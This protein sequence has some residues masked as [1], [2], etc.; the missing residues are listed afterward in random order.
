MNRTWL[1]V[2]LIG[3]VFVVLFSLALV[4]LL[5]PAPKTTLPAPIYLEVKYD[6]PI[7][8]NGKTYFSS[9]QDFSVFLDQNSEVKVL[10]NYVMS[11]NSR[12]AT[13][14]Y[15][16]E[17][18]DDSVSVREILY[19][20]KFTETGWGVFGLRSRWKCS[21]GENPGQWTIVSCV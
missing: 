12:D 1:T 2:G 9:P 6:A 4:R 10:D 7:A 15:L 20:L 16:F 5:F 17:G 21:R 19:D 13:V 3:A 18:F 8:V 11:D 14:R